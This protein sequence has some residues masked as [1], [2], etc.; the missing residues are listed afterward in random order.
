MV[1]LLVLATAFVLFANPFGRFVVIAARAAGIQLL[2]TAGFAFKWIFALFL[3]SSTLTSV[4]CLLLFEK[5]VSF[6]ERFRI[7]RKITEIL[8]N[9]Q[10]TISTTAG[11][12]A[13]VVAIAVLDFGTSPIYAAAACAMAKTPR[14]PA[15]AGLVLGNA[16]SFLALYYFGQAFGKNLV[17]LALAALVTT[18]LAF[19]VFFLYFRRRKA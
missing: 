15:I 19:A 10:K 18:A 17:S 8:E 13:L 6:A 2:S 3:F 1:D 12:V 4:F 16:L 7:A 14:K 11:T 5:T 9:A